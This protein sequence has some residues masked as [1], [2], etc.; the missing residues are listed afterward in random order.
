MKDLRK[1]NTSQSSC[2]HVKVQCLNE[3]ELIRKYRCL[4]CGGVMMCACNEHIGNRFVPHQLDEGIELKTQTRVSV[5][6]G[7]QTA[8]CRECRDMRPKAHPRAQTYGQSSK[9]RRYYWREITFLE[10][11]KIAAWA[12]SKGISIEQAESMPDV[13]SRFEREALED[14]KRL[15]ATSPKYVYKE[16]SDA[17]VLRKYQV[18]V[19]PHKA[20]YVTSSGNKRILVFDDGQSLNV[21]EFA[22][23]YF[24][25]L[26]YLRPKLG[27]LA[28]S[29]GDSAHV[30]VPTDE[31]RGAIEK[32]FNE[33]IHRKGLQDIELPGILVLEH[34]MSDERSY[35]GGAAF[36]SFAPLLQDFENAD[37][38][39]N[40][41]K[42]SFKSVHDEMQQ[43]N[44]T[45]DRAL[46]NLKLTPGLW[47][48]G[49][50]FKPHLI[51]MIRR[52]RPDRIE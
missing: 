51:S 34:A 37:A 48:I 42:E 1:S 36:I 32:E 41:V 27:S 8:V 19:I 12:D 30:F 2:N 33:W 28:L 20:T 13:R 22:I 5:T 9:I 52:L 25:R 18:E 40:E 39:I 11:E 24:R 10:W 44:T 46:R 17:E 23:N 15:H 7:F 21:E 50:D 3:Y 47:G 29:F 31:D 43:K 6:L 14:I 45:L 49:Y 26:G 38:L 4:Q 16:M 35:R